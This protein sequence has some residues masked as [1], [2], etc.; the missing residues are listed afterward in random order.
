MFSSSQASTT[1]WK[2]VFIDKP[3]SARLLTSAAL[4]TWTLQKPR[5]I[6]TFKLSKLTRKANTL[7]QIQAVQRILHECPREVFGRNAG[8]HV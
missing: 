3:V 2:T 4:S 8:L 6:S 7:A 5:K 1:F